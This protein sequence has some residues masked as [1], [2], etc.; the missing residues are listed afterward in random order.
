MESSA[1]LRLPEE[2]G[3]SPPPVQAE[4]LESYP[5]SGTVL[6]GTVVDGQIPGFDCVAL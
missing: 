1:G 5:N 4:S 6:L 2:L 3:H